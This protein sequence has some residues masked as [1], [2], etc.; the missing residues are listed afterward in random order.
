MDFPP[1]K[2]LVML[3]MVLSVDEAAQCHRAVSA[4]KPLKKQEAK[5][6]VSAAY[7]GGGGGRS[8]SLCTNRSCTGS[9]IFF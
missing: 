1:P 8:D 7:V 2:A 5:R 6:R 3:F 4:A 9:T